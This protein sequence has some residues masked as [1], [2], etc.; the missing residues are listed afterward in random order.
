VYYRRVT[1][2]SVKD[3]NAVFD[4]IDHST[5]NV[6]VLDLLPFLLRGIA[7][8]KH[9]LCCLIH[10]HGGFWKAFYQQGSQVITAAEDLTGALL[11][12]HGALG[13]C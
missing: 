13:T 2:E 4:F 5:Q 10:D 7:E 6:N 3:V 11:G 9:D 1:G 12:K 8:G